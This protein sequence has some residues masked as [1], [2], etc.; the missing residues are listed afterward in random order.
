MDVEPGLTVHTRRNAVMTILENVIK[1]SIEAT[2]GV[3]DRLV[4]I[5]AA[6]GEGAHTVA[7][8][9]S[10]NGRG[11]PEEAIASG[12]LDVRRSDYFRRG[13]ST[14]AGGSGL[15]MLNVIRALEIIDGKM[16]MSN[17]PAGVQSL[18]ILTNRTTGAA[19]L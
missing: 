18:L 10:H 1:N 16:T 17:L 14:R 19:V 11:L 3:V 2:E 7:V 5:R 6:R 12:V 8:D 9:I 4:V 15:G 13:K